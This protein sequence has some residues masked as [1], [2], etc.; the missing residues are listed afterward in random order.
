MIVASARTEGHTLKSITLKW[1]WNV[2]I[3]YERSETT[4]VLCQAVNLGENMAKYYTVTK[5]ISLC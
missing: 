3:C 1:K 2:M 4:A 5:K